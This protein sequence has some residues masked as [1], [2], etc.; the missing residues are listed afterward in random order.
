M[1]DFLVARWLDCRG[2]DPAEEPHPGTIYMIFELGILPN[3]RSVL[4]SD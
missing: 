3:L 1:V 4:L 2:R